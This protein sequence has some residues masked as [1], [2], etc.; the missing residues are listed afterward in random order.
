MSFIDLHLHTNFSDGV[1]SPEEVVKNAHDKGL[2][3]IA[4]TDHDTTDGIQRAQEAA[5]KYDIEL[6]PGIE[7]SAYLSD[8]FGEE[9]HI[10][11][12]FI[13]WNNEKFQNTLSLLKE[14]RT[15]R[16]KEILNKLYSLGVK[17]D[18]ER[19]FQS[20]GRGA[21][22]RLHFA[23]MMLEEGYVASIRDA[24]LEYL[25]DGRPA[26]VPKMYLEPKE[27]I[28]IISDVKGIPVLAHPS[29]GEIDDTVIK[30]LMVDGLK[31]IEV[32]CGR[33]NDNVSKYYQ[34]LA[35]QYDLLI[36]GGS[37][38]H[39]KIGTR[40]MLMGTVQVPYSILEELKKY[41]EANFS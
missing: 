7:L 36:T 11:G 15:E 23:K 37:D 10:L 29:Y 17:I 3:A 41:K 16:A 14:K 2:V 25:G 18:E 9:I 19:L 22:G 20:V 38:C 26:Y 32:F 28:N 13:D 21:I 33:L 6:I 31:G 35:Q 8:V 24:F 40:D 1:L 34:K 30:K 27:T 12:Y 4:I 39:G 5:E